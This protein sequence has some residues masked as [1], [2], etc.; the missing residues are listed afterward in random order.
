MKKVFLYSIAIIAVS[1]AFMAFTFTSY[2][3]TLS[4]QEEVK[5]GFP[6]DVQ[7]I[8]TTSCYDCHSTE[9][10]NIKAKSKLNFSKWNDYSSAKKVGKLEG[11]NE[12]IKENDMPPGKYL[13][14]HPDRALT[15]E[16]KELVYK[17]VTE[18]TNK[19]M[20]E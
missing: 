7:E 9:G 12:T 20:G 13:N 18:E 15:D 5:S 2:N 10:S 6:E 16:Q 4:P 19:L 14:K 3:T 11:I 17:W 1:L 8:I